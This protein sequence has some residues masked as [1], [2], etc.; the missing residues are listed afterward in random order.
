MVNHLV[1]AAS[2]S[3]CVISASPLR[4]ANLKRSAAAASNAC[5]S[6]ARR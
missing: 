1:V 6:A 5:G 3:H 4:E 2:I